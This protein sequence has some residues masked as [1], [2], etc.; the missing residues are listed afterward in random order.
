MRRR[1]LKLMLLGIIFTAAVIMGSAALAQMQEVRD[2]TVTH[3]ADIAD[4]P[5]GYLVRNTGGYIGVYYQNRRYPVFITEI[6]L[7]TLIAYDR[8]EIKQGI[9]VETRQ[10][11]VELLEDLGS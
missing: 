3:I 2:Y 10:E 1:T 6:P 8:E 9:S 5:A 7:A 4:N 11:L